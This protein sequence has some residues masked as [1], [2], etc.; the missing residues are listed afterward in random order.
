MLLSA[1]NLLLLA[2]G[3]GFVIF[4][5][6]LGHFLAAKWAKVRVEQFAVGFGNAIFSW[7]KGLGL[8]RGS[9]Q[10][11]Y[12]KLQEADP[13]AAVEVSPTEYRLNWIPLGGYVKMLGQEDFAVPDQTHE[14]DS[15][16]SKTVGQRMVII[17]GGVVMNVILAAFGFALL[18]FIGFTTPAPVVGVV[19]PGDPADRGG[20]EVGDR[21]LSV[22]GHH[23][24]DFPKLRLTIALLDPNEP[25]TFVV[26]PAGTSAEGDQRSLEILP[27]SLGEAN[28]MLA[29]GIGNTPSLKASDTLEFGVSDTEPM[30]RS[31]PADALAVMPGETIVAVDGEPL[32]ED[33]W[34]KLRRAAEEAGLRGKSLVLDVKTKGGQVEQRSV[35]PRVMRL[36]DDGLLGLRPALQVESIS[37]NSPLAPGSER[38]EGGETILQ[39]GDV[40]L[41]VTVPSSKDRLLVP[42][43]DSL[44]KL[45][46]EAGKAGNAVD[47]LV[48][49]GDE[50]VT[51]AGVELV[52][53]KSK[54]IFGFQFDIETYG[55]SVVFFNAMD[56]PIVSSVVADKSPADEANVEQLIA[57]QTARIVA[58][59]GADVAN[60]F[61]VATQFRTAASANPAT[62]QPADSDVTVTLTLASDLPGGEQ[63]QDVVVSATPQ[64]LAAAGELYVDLPML[65]INPAFATVETTRQ[66]YNPF[67]AVWWGV[68]ETRDQILNMYLT[69]RRVAVD[70][71]VP[72]NQMTGPVGI[73]H[74]GTLVTER[75]YDWLLWFLA[76]ISANLAV[77]NFLPIPILDGGHMVFLAVEKVMG[78][79]PSPAV[80]AA[81]LYAGLALIGLMVVFVTVN[82]ISRLLS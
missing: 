72:A 41:S 37:P 5:H 64:Q 7:R 77:V 23:V 1:F 42:D 52:P 80:Q 34:Y 55:L 36:P 59:N 62:T 30:A 68:F 31:L 28:G 16:M 76:M 51:L 17:S 21:I 22:N 26:Q 57:T 29:V 49:R 20:M 43:L 74:F 75:G 54:S 50:Q 79:P 40:L 33:E 9:S 39:P 6:E 12:A 25:S 38:D 65:A 82:D 53:L 56:T 24:E 4:W 46:T 11:E 69:L 45:L 58:V 44:G 47:L 35:T 61:D 73:F 71:T 2:V 18:Y 63:R 32:A 67:Q 81:A 13:A 27:E 70:R 48:Q 66:T 3:F 10:D 19:T 8:R 78:R 14:P 60:W 15:Y